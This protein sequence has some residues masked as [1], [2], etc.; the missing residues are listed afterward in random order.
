MQI[1]FLCF[2]VVLLQPSHCNLLIKVLLNINYID[3]TFIEYIDIRLFWYLQHISLNVSLFM[4]L[5]FKFMMW[6]LTILVKIDFLVPLSFYTLPIFL[7]TPMGGFLTNY[8]VLFLK[9][10]LPSCACSTKINTI[11]LLW[12]NPVSQVLF[13]LTA[14]FNYFRLSTRLHFG[15]VWA[16]FSLLP[17]L[18]PHL[19]MQHKIPVKIPLILLCRC[20]TL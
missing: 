8:I 20:P 6:L 2:F 12:E 10:L 1:F 17:S 7:T 15:C 5:W 14:S 19:R 3:L 4:I 9:T 13:A 11:F 18:P 16:L